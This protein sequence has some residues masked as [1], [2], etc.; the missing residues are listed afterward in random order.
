MVSENDAGPPRPTPTPG[1]GFASRSVSSTAAVPLVALK[2]P[3]AGV[4]SVVSLVGLRCASLGEVTVEV[5]FMYSAWLLS[6]VQETTP[7][8]SRT[9]SVSEVT[10]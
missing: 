6:S 4:S 9:H 2:A 10:V 1:S 5:T 7:L 3:G 8:A